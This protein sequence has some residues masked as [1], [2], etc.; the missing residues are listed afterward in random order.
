M[1]NQRFSIHSLTGFGINGTHSLYFE[2]DGYKS[3][4]IENIL[5]ENQNIVKIPEIQLVRKNFSKQLDQSGFILV[6]NGS[7]IHDDSYVEI[8]LGYSEEAK[9]MI[10]SEHSNFEDAQ[11]EPVLTSTQYQFDQGG[12]KTLYLKFRNSD[13]IESA[14]FSDQIDII[15]SENFEGK[16]EVSDGAYTSENLI[17]LNI[18]IPKTAVEMLVCLRNNFSGCV[19]EKVSSKKNLYIP[20]DGKYT[21]FTKYRSKSGKESPVYSTNVIVDTSAPVFNLQVFFDG[22][23][24]SFTL[25]ISDSDLVGV[26]KMKI[27]G[28]PDHSSDNW[29]GF[30]NSFDLKYY[31]GLT[32]HVQL[33]DHI[34]HKSE[35]KSIDI[36]YDIASIGVGHIGLYNDT[37]SWIGSGHVLSRKMGDLL[38]YMRHPVYNSDS[39]E[40]FLVF[41]KKSNTWDELNFPIINNGDVKYQINSNT[42]FLFEE[43]DLLW[44]GNASD[45]VDFYQ[46][47]DNHLNCQWYE[48]KMSERKNYLSFGKVGRKTLVAGGIIN[49]PS[50]NISNVNSDTVDVFD[51]SEIPCS[52]SVERLS[53]A[54]RL[55][56]TAE[57]NDRAIFAGG[58]TD[59]SHRTNRV[60]IYD[61]S[62]ETCLWNVDNLQTSRSAMAVASLGNQ[63]IFAGGLL[64]Y[65]S[66]EPFISDT[67][68]I[69]DCGFET[70]HHVVSSLSEP[71]YSMATTEL[72]EKAYFAGGY[73]HDGNSQGS[74][75]PSKRVDIYNC[76]GNTCFWQ[77]EELSIARV[78]STAIS[79]GN[80]VFFAGGY[81]SS[82][83][84]P[85][86]SRIDIYDDLSES[87]S[88]YEF[89][90]PCKSVNSEKYDGKIIFLGCNHGLI[91]D[92]HSDTWSET[93]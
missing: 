33:V 38:F 63:A 4:Q 56:S 44:P 25:N 67:V 54:R 59:N 76:S 60:D 88:T 57:V 68:D 23:S 69:F 79:I 90:I 48:A 83:K 10:I 92:S 39:P 51:C 15:L 84:K 5:I 31:K 11:W 86:F 37:N 3:G 2:K 35:I 41:D 62:G 74:I 14:V 64:T 75:E 50:K 46:C 49:D 78:V 32:L 24:D 42:L 89:P 66:G 82:L 73:R 36:R 87:W 18:E 70:C 21:V 28:H 27:T 12:L 40:N 65:R 7:D 55:I 47:E 26:D 20:Q 72:N 1:Q 19:W 6:Q 58:Q 16:I 85:V 8:T 45:N 53:L 91:Y 71:R 22:Y 17:N 29:V 93:M 61:C 52:H 80:K 77:I 43:S 81:E 13:G 30:K 34:G 9:E